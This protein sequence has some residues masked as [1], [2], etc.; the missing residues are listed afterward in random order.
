MADEIAFAFFI[1]DEVEAEEI[2]L[3]YHENQLHSSSSRLVPKI[4]HFVE[5]VVPLYRATDFRSHFRLSRGRVEDLMTTLGPHYINR[6]RTKLPVCNSV[7]ACLWTLSNQESYRGVTLVTSGSWHDARAFRNT[8]VARLLEEDPRALVPEGMHIIGDSAYPLLRK[9][10]KPYRDNGHLTARQRRFNQKL[11]AA[12]VAIAHAFGLLKS[13]F[14][15]LKCLYMKEVA[16]I[17][18][19]VTAYCI[20]H[21]ICLESGD[22]LD[23]DEQGLQLREDT[24]DPHPPQPNNQD[25]SQYRD[26]I[27]AQI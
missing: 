8:D 20:L 2:P 23:E 7:L 13:K 17:S 18:S 3:L 19:T 27:C 14:R 5:E 24:D 1:A 11:T 9:R 15:R 25:A 4:T 10:M 12:R 22:Q 6:Q 16:S 26:M 21:N